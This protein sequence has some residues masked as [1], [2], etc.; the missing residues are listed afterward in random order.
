VTGFSGLGTNTLTWSINP[1][2]IGNLAIV[3]SGTGAN[4]LSDAA[5]TGLNAGAGFAQAL[6]ILWGDFDDDG[7]VSATDLVGV[8]NATKTAYNVFADLNGDGAVNTAD[9]QI[10]RARAGTS[11]P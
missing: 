2:P 1:V 9:V 7:A 5:G 3:L 8:N 4:A 10:V 6:K 11:L